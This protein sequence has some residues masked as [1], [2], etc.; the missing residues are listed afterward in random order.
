[1]PSAAPEATGATAS[2]APQ[3]TP[4][5]SATG[6][7]TASP[8][9]T[10]TGTATATPT[11]APTN[12]RQITCPPVAD[13]IMIP[14]AVRSDVALEL[15][16]M[17]LLESDV[18]DRI[19]ATQSQADQD[20]LLQRLAKERSRHLARIAALLDRAGGQVT[21]DLASLATCERNNGALEDDNGGTGGGAPVPSDTPAPT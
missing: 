14:R 7:G 12:S 3:P 21:G 13:Q 1:N 4:S 11:P 19:A 15:G 20:A 5:P 16:L 9:A 2:P 18:N 8:S 17:E 10:P 6:T